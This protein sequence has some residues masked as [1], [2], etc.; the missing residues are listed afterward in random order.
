MTKP[1]WPSYISVWNAALQSGFGENPE[2]NQVAFQPET[3]PAILR[4]RTSISQ[5]LTAFTLRVNAYQYE[6]IRKF[7]RHTVKDG[8]LSFTMPH[9][10][11]RTTGTWQFVP[12]NPPKITAAYGVVY[13][14]QLQ[15]RLLDGGESHPIMWALYDGVSCDLGSASDTPTIFDD[16]GCVTDAPAV[17]VDLG[18]LPSPPPSDQQDAQ[19]LGMP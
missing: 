1:A 6:Q 10:R 16:L 18:G 4:R 14:V 11:N 19:P 2:A 3:G 9:P 15:L 5:D 8:T 13:D 7:Y 12:G 17:S